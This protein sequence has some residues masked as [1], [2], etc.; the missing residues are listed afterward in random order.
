VIEVALTAIGQGDDG[1]VA[2]SHY[3]NALACQM[4]WR[5]LAWRASAVAKKGARGFINTPERPFR[6]LVGASGIE[7]PTTTMS[8]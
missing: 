5:A 1:H 4:R 8:R 7:P 2:F 3:S 6:S